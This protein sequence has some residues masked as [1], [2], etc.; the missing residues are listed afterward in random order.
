M[1]D[2]VIVV[3]FV[4]AFLLLISNRVRNNQNWSATVTPLASII[5]S[6][7]LVSVPLLASAVGI[8]AVVAVAM[9]TV[10]AYLIGGA[11]R[12]NIRFGEPI[13]EA[14][15]GGHKIKSVET[16][17]HLV[18]I[19]AYFIS[20]SYYLVLLAAFG[21]K[22]LGQT[23]PMIGKCV[24]SAIVGSIALI[25]AIKGLDGVQRAEKFTVSA[26]LASIAALIAALLIFGVELP[27]EYSWEAA[28]KQH[29]QINGHTFRFV[30]GLLI[31]VQGF[32]TS[33]FMG[34]LYDAPTRIAAMRRSQIVSTIVYLIFFALMIPLYPYFTSTTDVA[35][36]I[37]VIG[38]VTSWLPFVVTAGAVASQFSAAVADSIGASGLIAE[39]TDKRV[40]TNHAYIVIGVVGLIVIWSTDVVSVVA[41][42]SR[43]FALFYALQCAVATLI[44]N[45][46]GEKK[47]ATGYGVLSA[48]SALVAILGIPASG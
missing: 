45:H 21:M 1:L 43:A 7:F 40:N 30:M 29:E 24:S 37:T 8:W 28:A 31:I 42:A 34:S 9:L 16:I 46:R 25:G 44:A 36:F 48:V 18:L 33:R 12:Y 15:N 14:A 13:F 22:L 19:G 10:L 27:A 6:G 26:N 23:D 2:S 35:G 4:G 17:S 47:R 38:R 41:L 5:G 39:T 32:E 11:I 20:V 3:V